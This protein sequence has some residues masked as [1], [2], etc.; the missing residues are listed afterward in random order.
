L[1]YNYFVSVICSTNY[2][3][4]FNLFGKKEETP[5]SIFTDRCYQTTN[6]KLNACAA[7]AK[8]QPH[9]YFICWFAN[10]LQLFKDF[11]TQQGLD[12]SLVVDAK[13]FNAAMLNNRQA[14]FTEHHPLHSKEL[15]LIKNWALQPIIVYSS[16]DEPLFV[17]FGSEK[18]L[19]LMKLLGMKEGEVIEHSFVTKS[20]IK[21]QNKIAGMVEVEQ[22]AQSQ[23]EWLDKNLTA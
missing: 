7:L 2:Y 22:S 8:T 6:A 13:N 16:M 19:G 23:K 1:V 5:Q 12:A 14:V 11:F 15:E 3:M 10:T 18:M 20:I 17:H 9:T 4:L 21:G